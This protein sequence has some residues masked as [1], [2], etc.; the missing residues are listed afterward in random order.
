MPRKRLNIIS[1]SLAHVEAAFR[2]G[3]RPVTLKDIADYCGVSKCTVSLALRDRPPISQETRETIL[4]AAQRLGYEPG[5]HEGARRLAF[6]KQGKTVV[7]RVVA[8]FFP[9]IPTIAPGFFNQLFNGVMEGLMAEEYGLL[10]LH[11]PSF[12][13]ASAESPLW[14]IFMRGDVDGVIVG[15]AMEDRLIER[16]RSNPGFGQRPIVKLINASAPTAAVGP[17]GH[18]GGYRIAQHLL[19]LGHRHFLH[20]SFPSGIPGEVQLRLDGIGQALQ[21]RGLS[22]ADHICCYQMTRNWNN[23]STAPHSISGPPTPDFMD[24]HDRAFIGFLRQHLDITAIL[25]VNDATALHAWHALHLAGFRVPDDYSLVGC[26]DTDP[27][28]NASRENLLTTLRM[29][30]QEIGLEAAHLIVR[31]ISTPVSPPPA[32]MLPTELILRASTGPARSS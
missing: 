5:V 14:S 31:L 25:G 16:L 10:T 26:D 8:L 29:P 28:L 32:L 7:N 15:H 4:A 21:E 13:A 2:Q 19:D 27:M 22:P 17:D 18:Q 30:L 20:L 24:E 11:S 3:D 12:L 1:P 6:R 9:S 23:P